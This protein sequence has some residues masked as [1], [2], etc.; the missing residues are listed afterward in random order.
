MSQTSIKKAGLEVKLGALRQALL[1]EMK[2][3]DFRGRHLFIAKLRLIIFI[4]CWMMFIVFFPKIWVLSPYVPLIFNVGFFITSLC[5]L[6]IIREKYVIFMGI[7][8]VLAD[9][10]SQTS[11]LYLLGPDTAVAFVF[12]GLYVIGA[13]SFFGYLVS[14]LSAT[15]ALVS[16]CGLLFLMNTGIVAPFNYPTVASYLF[17]IEG[18]GYIF[19][20]IFLP[21]AL[22]VV[23]YASKIAYYFSKIKERALET[24]NV[25]LL[26]LNRI[27][28]TIRRAL[29]LQSVIDQVLK[30]V[31]QGLGFDVCFLALLS[32]EEKVIHFYVPQAN[33]LTERIEE[34]WGRKLSD[35]HLPLK[36]TNNS[37]Y[38]SILKNRVI[39][40]NEMVE[41]TI[42][43]VP[44]IDQ[45]RTKKVQKEIGFKKFVVTP[46]V[47][48][49]KVV[50][51]LIGASRKAYVE[52]S[53]IDTLDN[54]AN[55]AALALESA[56]LFEELQ[57]K[58]KQLEEANKI[59]S[60]F[61]AIMSHELRTPLT[62]IIGY[63]EILLDNVLG[64]LRIEQKDSLSEVLKNAENL[65]QLI[66]SILDLAKVEAGKMEL[67]L[68]SFPIGEVITEVYQTVTP[69]VGRKKQELSIVIPEGL[70]SLEADPRK[71]RQILLNLVGNAIK[72]TPDRGKIE[73]KVDYS[74]DSTFWLEEF[75][76]KPEA[77]ENRG[78]FKITVADNG[79]GIKEEHLSSIFDIFQQVDS[80]FTRR[81]QG[82]GLGLALTKQLVELHQG[83]IAVESKVG[84]GSLF[85]FLLPS[86]PTS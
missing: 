42:G 66:N 11:I 75:S 55:Q 44:P 17:R 69:L 6:N 53:V 64:E 61:L 21:I 5:Y 20:L 25:Q 77:Y 39:I 84:Q 49:R 57:Q 86:R 36:S 9:V 85:K 14:L 52:E 30:G 18:F 28:S 12:Y 15:A 78:L 43:L 82:T 48:E 76:Y 16:Y 65:L 26:A 54:F 67:N 10:I 35:L 40:R 68:E 1:Q 19:N 50:G 27:G 62:A 70:P 45:E 4:L 7:L 13:G 71:L 46:L 51:A 31:I 33:A 29:N 32:K 72:F 2:L 63:S 56:Q 47:A 24:R 58:N 60:D 23:V 73:V 34:I 22:G 8:E 41:L 81:Y 38:Q 79:I 74:K 83:V 59:K 37:A 80:T 3:P